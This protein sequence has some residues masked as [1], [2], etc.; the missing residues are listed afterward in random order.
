MSVDPQT[1]TSSEGDVGNEGSGVEGRE[2]KHRTCLL[3][4]GWLQGSNVAI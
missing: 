2:G 3:A 1:E 4:N